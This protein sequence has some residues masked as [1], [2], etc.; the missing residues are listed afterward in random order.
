MTFSSTLYGPISSAPSPCNGSGPTGTAQP[1]RRP[2]S[3]GSIDKKF[4]GRLQAG[5]VEEH[6]R[7]GT[8]RATCDHGGSCN[9]RLVTSDD[10]SSMT[11]H[12]VRWRGDSLSS[13]RLDAEHHHISLFL[14][15]H[16]SIHRIE[17]NPGKMQVDR[18]WPT[19]FEQSA[20]I[21]RCLHCPQSVTKH[22][23]RSTSPPI[24]EPFSAQALGARHV[25]MYLVQL[26]DIAHP[27]MLDGNRTLSTC[28]YWIRTSLP[29]AY[30]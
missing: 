12:V 6:I 14:L 10:M 20:V 22:A 5:G 8:R 17:N 11:I 25:A 13:F 18:P 21:V 16:P 1:P 26:V 2:P 3:L 15:L 7:Q 30:P 9:S 23:S 28:N 27:D 4:R 29:E 24:E 19:A